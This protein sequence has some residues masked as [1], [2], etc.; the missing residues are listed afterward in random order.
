M[1][2]VN[3]YLKKAEESTGKSLIYLKY[4]YNGIYAFVFS[5]GQS[6]KPKDWNGK[7][8]RVKSN[9]QTTADGQ[10]SLND[11]LDNL[12]NECEAA[13]RKELKNGIP[14]PETLKK[15][16][17]YFLNQNK[18]DPN[19]PTLFKLIDRFTNNEI[20]HRG[21]SKSSNTLKKYK[22]VLNHLK[23]FEVKKKYPI[24]FESITLDF[25]YKYLVFLKEKNLKPNSIAKDIQVIK[26]F[27]NEAFDLGFTKN[28]QHKHRKFAAAWV[29][30]DSV[31]LTENQVINLYNYDLSKNK[32][33]EQVRDLFVFGCFTGLRFADYS[34]V[35]P[36]NIISLKDDSSD[37]QELFIKIVTKKTGEEVVIPCD[38]IVLKLFEKYKANPNRLPTSISNQKFNEYIK[39]AC[40]EAK[41]E[42][43][44][45]LVGEPDKELW[46]C[47]SSHSA[48][49]SFAT[50]YYLQG[51]PTIDLMKI[52]GHRTEKA[53]LTYIKV[54]KLDA[55]KRLSLH[56]KKRWSEKLLKVA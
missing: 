4:K 34:S 12:Q 26:T 29:P 24:N 51:F 27:M 23:E 6:V 22:T 30:V 18:E 28:V 46:E 54:S 8:Q 55:A 3:F 33:L 47:I 44:G 42:E 21:Q 37:K 7:K 10:Y 13:Y 11:L 36:E 35:K 25:F 53:F 16:L 32:K 39:N 52:T 9:N 49:R 19:R 48:R 31:Y 20:Y 41:L 38:P 2:A 56:I 1:G 45:L 15:Y 43:K 40:K 14:Q 5:F 50:N 17:I